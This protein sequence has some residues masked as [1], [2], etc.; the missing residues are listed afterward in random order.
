MAPSTSAPAD[1]ASNVREGTPVVPGI[2]VGPVI[3][4]TAAV[5]MSG[6][7][8]I[9]AGSAED[10]GN[11]FAKAV[12]TVAQ[13][14][15][16][17]ALEASGVAAEVLSAQVGLV[18]DKGLRK[19]VDKA[20]A[21][22]ASA[23]AATAAAVDQFSAMFQQLGRPDGR[24]GHGP[25]RSRAAAWWPSCRVCPSRASRCPHVAFDPGRRGPCPG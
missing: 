6:L 9:V 2:A 5:D 4:P 10:E 13:R 3:R 7:S 25:A 24:A 18:S 19:S 21:G 11:R 15:Q 16:G 14:L 20:I 1:S 22:G 17:R 23:E 12:E 8:S